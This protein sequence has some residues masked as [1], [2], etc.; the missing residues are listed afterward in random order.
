[1]RCPCWSPDQYAHI[2]MHTHSRQGTQV[3]QKTQP[4]LHHL[5]IPA[6]EA[7]AVNELLQLL[8]R[9]PAAGQR[10]HSLQALPRPSNCTLYPPAITPHAH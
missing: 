6:Y 3:A 4:Q 5:G 8:H 2:A 1:V 10:P 9:H 7:R